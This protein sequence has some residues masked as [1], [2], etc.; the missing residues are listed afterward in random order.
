MCV[1]EREGGGGTVSGSK[2]A[3]ELICVHFICLWADEDEKPA[4]DS[5]SKVTKDVGQEK[6]EAVPLTRD[7]TWRQ[8]APVREW[9]IGKESEY[10]ALLAPLFHGSLSIVSCQRMGHWQKERVLCTLAALFYGTL[11]CSRPIEPISKLNF[12]PL[13]HQL[14]QFATVSVCLMNMLMI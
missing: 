3:E 14:W 2:I 7:D 6:E 8:S 1:R 5:V 13:T 11:F 12:L 4:E 10:C 9:D